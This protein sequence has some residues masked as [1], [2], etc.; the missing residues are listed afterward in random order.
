[1]LVVAPRID[2]S[3]FHQG[4]GVRGPAGDLMHY[5]GLLA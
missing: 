5:Q 2:F 4:Q 1:M 3:V